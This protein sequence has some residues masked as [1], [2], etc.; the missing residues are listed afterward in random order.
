MQGFEDPLNRGSYPWGH[1]D[2]SLQDFFRTLGKLRKSRPSLQE[3]EIRYLAADGG[4]LVLERRLGDEITVCAINAGDT[5]RELELP[6]QDTVA[7]DVANGQRFLLPDRVLR[8]TLP[9]LNGA[10]LI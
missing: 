3:G 2:I 6:W 1:E 9:P 7:A 8:L 5:P 4:L 10:I